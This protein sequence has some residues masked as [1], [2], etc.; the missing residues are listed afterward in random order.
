MSRGGESDYTGVIFLGKSFYKACLIGLAEEIFDALE[1][2]VLSINKRALYGRPFVYGIVVVMCVYI[3]LQRTLN[4]IVVE[5]G[6]V[7]LFVIQ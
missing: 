1:I 7:E 3:A 4:T 6:I 5:F 2:Q